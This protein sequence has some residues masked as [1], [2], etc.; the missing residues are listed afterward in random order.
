[1][2]KQKDGLQVSVLWN[3]CEDISLL[4]IRPACPV[5]KA[6]AWVKPQ[7]CQGQ[8]PRH[9]WGFM[10]ALTFPKG[11]NGLCIPLG[12]DVSYF[13]HIQAI[14]TW[15]QHF[16]S[17]HNPPVLTTRIQRQTPVCNIQSVLEIRWSITVRICWFLR[18]C[19]NVALSVLQLTQ[20]IQN[21]QGS[22]CDRLL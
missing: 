19:L 1:M 7:K 15:A 14:L 22:G 5:G 3:A 10:K 17:L 8:N 20:N 2:R 11:Y 6:S 4:D 9:F 21:D 18:E 13:Y 16:N 12:R